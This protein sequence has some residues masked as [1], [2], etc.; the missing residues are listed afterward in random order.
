MRSAQGLEL[1]THE[2]TNTSLQWLHLVLWQ[3]SCERTGGICYIDIE[4]RQS[5]TS[6]LTTGS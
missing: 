1:T 3:E 5:I 4:D 6:Q 2:Q